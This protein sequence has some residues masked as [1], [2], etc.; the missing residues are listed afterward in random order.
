MTEYK[1]RPRFYES[2]YIP[3]IKLSYEESMQPVIE[4]I[5]Q[6]VDEMVINSCLK[7]G[8]NVDK[9]RLIQVLNGDR[10]QYEKGE[11]D[12]FSLITSAWH[13]KEYYFLQ[14]DGSVYSR[15]SGKC[16]T[17]NEAYD[18]FLHEIGVYG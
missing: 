3:P 10:S 17:K 4:R 16:L 5:A 8:I 13:G 7:V 14:D 18:E 11:W 1:S 15:E 2:G 9:K 12:M 6:G